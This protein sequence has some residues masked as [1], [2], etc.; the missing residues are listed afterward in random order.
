MRSAA[1]APSAPVCQG[2]AEQ[3]YLGMTL[4]RTG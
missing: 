2:V 3:G 4:S 1:W